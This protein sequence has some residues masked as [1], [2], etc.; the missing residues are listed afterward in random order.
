MGVASAA[1][2]D[3]GDDDDEGSPPGVE[4]TVG[5]WSG[6]L[7]MLLALPADSNLFARSTS[8]GV[9]TA[10]ADDASEDDNNIGKPAGVGGRLTA[11]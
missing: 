4:G 3:A 8:L 6:S 9:A 11:L 2:G 1:A 7:L 10:A 5:C